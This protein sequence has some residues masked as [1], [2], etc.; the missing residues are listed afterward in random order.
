M[1]R[2]LAPDEV[3]TLLGELV[4][5]TDVLEDLKRRWVWKPTGSTGRRKG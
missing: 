3:R 5:A 4:D 1:A 2:T